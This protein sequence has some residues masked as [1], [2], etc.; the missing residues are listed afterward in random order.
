MGTFTYDS[1]LTIDFD[2]RLLLHLQVVISAKL[3]RDESFLFSWSR[4]DPV[5]GRTSVW[6][7]K[8]ISL[9]FDYLG[10]AMPTLNRQWIEDLTKAAYLQSGLQ[11]VPEPVAS[12][13]ARLPTGHR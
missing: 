11:I 1:A 5:G 9:V 6:I 13:P 2:D 10:S 4:P 7:D 12:A 3:R 8:H